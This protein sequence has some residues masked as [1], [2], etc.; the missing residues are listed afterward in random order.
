M[1]NMC[2]HSFSLL[3][4]NDVFCTKELFLLSPLATYDVFYKKILQKFD[5]IF[6]F[7]G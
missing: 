1:L 2:S 5:L 3:G 4:K 6:L 7:L